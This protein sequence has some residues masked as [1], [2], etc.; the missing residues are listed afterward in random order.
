[1]S[2]MESTA[3]QI[4]ADIE[5]HEETSA[6]TLTVYEKD[7]DIFCG[8]ESFELLLG[9][10]L[11]GQLLADLASTLIDRGVQ[12]RFVVFN[13]VEYVAWLEEN[14]KS[15]SRESRISWEE[16]QTP[17]EHTEYAGKRRSQSVEIGPK[18]CPGCNKQF[19]NPADFYFISDPAGDKAHLCADC[20]ASAASMQ[21]ARYD[22]KTKT[23][24]SDDV[25][26]LLLELVSRSFGG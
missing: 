9:A 15:D 25:M 20:M 7:E 26:K 12:V 8:D 11:H 1:M 23:H 17:T 10:D 19:E 4:V 3:T 16:E 5:G 21:L 24:V 6:I 13:A 18:F 2:W 22:Y 14:E